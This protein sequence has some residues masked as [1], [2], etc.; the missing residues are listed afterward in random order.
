MAQGRLPS[1][2]SS[3]ARI[4]SIVDKRL[5]YAEGWLAD[6][7]VMKLFKSLASVQTLDTHLLLDYWDKTAVCGE[8]LKTCSVVWN[9]HHWL[10]FLDPSCIFNRWNTGRVI[11]LLQVTRPTE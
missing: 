10:S 5:K 1:N 7:T 9:E 3:S 4:E 6:L 11:V 8:S 2:S